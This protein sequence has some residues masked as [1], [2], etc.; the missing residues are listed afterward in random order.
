[1][2]GAVGG[3]VAFSHIL[4]WIYKKYKDQTVSIL[5]GFI[6]GSLAILWPWKNQIYKLDQTGNFV[7]KDGEKIVQ[8]YTRYMP[9]SFDQEVFA[10]IGFMILGIITISL[11]EKIARKQN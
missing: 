2:S 9:E 8:G 6:L 11:I 3:L 7:L 4:S 10:A 5:T 1:M